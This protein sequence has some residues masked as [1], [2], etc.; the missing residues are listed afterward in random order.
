M[1]VNRFEQLRDRVSANWYSLV[2]A[3]PVT[4]ENVALLGYPAPQR[5]DT[6]GQYCVREGCKYLS[7]AELDQL[8]ICA[9]H[10]YRILFIGSS[11][12][13]GAGAMTGSDTDFL[14][15]ATRIGKSDW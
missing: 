11:Q 6:M 3:T 13:A 5:W 15:N 9:K 7:N 10:A 2:G 12:L 1:E 8:F 4:P 14:E